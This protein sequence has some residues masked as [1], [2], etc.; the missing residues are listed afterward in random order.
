MK[1]VCKIEAGVAGGWKNPIGVE[2]ELVV[3]EAEVYIEFV[4]VVTFL[5]ELFED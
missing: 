1:S 3:A 2:V 5:V 4:A